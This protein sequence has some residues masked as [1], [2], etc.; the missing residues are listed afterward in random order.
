[1]SKYTAEYLTSCFEFLD[2]LR[3]SGI[4]NMFGAGSYLCNEYGMSREESSEV[5]GMWMKT[6]S[7]DLSPSERAAK[8][9][10]VPA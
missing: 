2:D 4:T 10:Q 9:Q 8:A 3:D 6:F 5:L 7:Q 1:M